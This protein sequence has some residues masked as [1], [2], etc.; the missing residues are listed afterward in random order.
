MCIMLPFMGGGEKFTFSS[1][2]KKYNNKLKKKNGYFWKMDGNR[3]ERRSNGERD[4]GM[5]RR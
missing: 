1:V 4:T 2:Q 5:R 3:M